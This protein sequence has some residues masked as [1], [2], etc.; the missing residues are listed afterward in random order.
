[1]TGTFMS[2]FCYE[3]LIIVGISRLLFLHRVRVTSHLNLTADWSI[4]KQHLSNS[5]MGLDS[6]RKKNWHLIDW[7]V[8]YAA[9]NSISVISRRHLTFFMSLLGFI[10]S[11]LGLWSVLPRTLRRKDPD[12]PLR[13]ER[14][15]PG[16]RVEHFT[17]E[18]RGTPRELTQSAIWVCF[19]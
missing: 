19:D 4:S 6:K 3:M 12:N 14:M 1:M 13:L 8:C 7:I 9:L 11:R 10:S 18:S 2:Y 5:N 17:S 15:T 16:L